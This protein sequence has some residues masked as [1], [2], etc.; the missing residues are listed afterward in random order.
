MNRQLLSVLCIYLALVSAP[1]M[2]AQ[3]ISRPGFVADGV[4]YYAPLA[5]LLI[6]GDLDLRNELSQLNPAYLRAAYGTPEGTLGDPFPVGPAV[7]WA[8]TVWAVSKLPSNGWLDR[9]LRNPPRTTHVAFAPRFARAVQG[10]SG[11]LVL[12]GG[13]VL[14][15]ALASLVRGWLAAVVVAVLVWAT[16]VFYYVMVDPS[17]GHAASFFSV[18]L[19]TAASLR[20]PQKKLPLMILGALW[21][22]VALVRSQDAVFGLL[23]APRLIDDWKHG[24]G[25]RSR[26]G[27]LLRF[28]VPAILVFTPQMIFW[29]EIYGK[30]LLIPPGPDVLPL[31]KPQILHLLFSTWN[32]VLP[33]APLLLVGIVGLAWNNDRRWRLFA[34]GAIALQL[35]SSSILLD[36]WGGGSFGPRRLVSI[37][38]VAAVGLAFLLQQL[39]VRRRSLPAR[40]ALAGI[41]VL[42]LV[43]MLVPIRVAE[44]KLRG[45]IPLNPGDA[46]Q[47]VRQHAPGSPESQPWGHWDYLRVLRELQDAGHL[48][49]LDL[50]RQQ[51]DPD[52]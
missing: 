4:G 7:L 24:A 46:R 36:W 1:T 19:L 38:P 34:W 47:Y 18:A 40:L 26:L 33:W 50:R 31:W 17:Y 5:S 3:H 37:V 30:P 52:R 28:L 45:L 23:L 6:D 14:V 29:N 11:F 9:P 43:S 42:L 48:R 44:Y 8:P 16:P 27:L 51:A 20:D 12:V 22:L 21:G 2:L 15:T 39:V 32:G 49:R 25:W 13:A 10:C 35:Y 41:L